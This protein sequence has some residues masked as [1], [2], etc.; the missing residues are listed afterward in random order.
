MWHCATFRAVSSAYDQGGSSQDGGY[1]QSLLRAEKG[2]LLFE[3]SLLETQQSTSRETTVIHSKLSTSF[4]TTTRECHL[5]PSK[6]PK[7][8]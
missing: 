6:V 5:H 2:S 7:E 3:D 8:V 1:E 4:L